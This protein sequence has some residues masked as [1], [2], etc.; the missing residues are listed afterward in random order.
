MIIYFAFGKFNEV[1]YI[2]QT[3]MSLAMRKG[4]HLSLARNGS[5][6]PFHQAIVRIGEKNI[7]FEEYC[8]TDE[9]FASD[10]EIALIKKYRPLY[11]MQEGGKIG[12]TPWNKGKKMP[13]EIIDAIKVGAIG[14]KRSKRGS[15]TIE[16]KDKISKAHRERLSKPFVC[17][18]NYKT[19]Q[20]KVECS[21]DLGIPVGG[22][23]LV[24][25]KTSR[26]KSY[27]G[28]TFEYLALDKSSLI[29]LEAEKS[30]TG[31]KPK[32]SVND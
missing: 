3:K 22:I 15:Y 2:G 18:Q 14:R 24:L 32:G 17:H 7:S 6:I 29:D 30:V 12:Y 27:Y 4:K 21:E 10:L 31:R 8:K 11:N 1:L 28:Y 20:T 9:K 13:V 23:S 25:M 5:K 16:H 19:Y 26:L